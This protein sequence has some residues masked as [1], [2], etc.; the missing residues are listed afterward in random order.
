M[1]IRRICNHQVKNQVKIGALLLWRSLRDVRETRAGAIRRLCNVTQQGPPLGSYGH[2]LSHSLSHSRCCSVALNA[3]CVGVALLELEV[4]LGGGLVPHWV[5][6]VHRPYRACSK[7]VYSQV[8]RAAEASASVAQ[9]VS[10]MAIS[11]SSRKTRST[12]ATPTAPALANP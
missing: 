5:G 9:P 7:S 10:A 6:S 8:N 3:R 1:R 4:L 12:C 11:S 2:S